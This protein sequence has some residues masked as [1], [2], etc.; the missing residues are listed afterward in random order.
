MATEIERKFLVTGDRW[1]S[2]A[3][4]K[5]YRQGYLARGTATVRVRIVGER[6]Y[7]TIKGQ[8]DGICRLE[9]EYEIPIA[10]AQM[11]LDSLC[12]API[13]EKYRYP[14]SIDGYLWEVDEFL[15]A[16]AGLI[17]AEVE[18]TDETDQPT[19]PDWI[20]AEVSDD[21]RYYNANLAQHP[22]S[23]WSRD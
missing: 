12:D 10:D 18:L 20:G 15:G 3:E 5:L 2:L 23:Q 6:G 17:I 16:N 1:R 9:W 14:I 22:W 8:N 21:P 13:I 4:G 19:P 7:L 11:M